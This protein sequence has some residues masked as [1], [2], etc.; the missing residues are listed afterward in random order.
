M[1][2]AFLIA[3]GTITGLGAV[4]S[5]TPP[6]LSESVGTAGLGGGADLGGGAAT[7]ATPTQA[8]PTTGF[9][10]TVNGASFAAR[11]YGTVSVSATF[12]NGKIASVSASQ[13]P[14]SW[15][16]QS[17]SV[18]LPYVNAGSI[19]VEQVKQ[20]SAAELPCARSNS[21][22]SRASYTA[23]AFWN[24]LKSAITKAGL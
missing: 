20:Y 22:N 17:L 8:A 10:G 11:D 6:A 24:S 4:L 15:S 18:L 23:E 5:I 7:P 19:T 9:S 12:A 2:K 13:S 1:K 14:R 21:C 16:Q 3:A